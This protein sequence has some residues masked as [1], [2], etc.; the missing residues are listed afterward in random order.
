MA[1]RAEAMRADDM[2][3]EEDDFKKRCAQKVKRTAEW[4]AT[5]Q[6]TTGKVIALWVEHKK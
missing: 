3:G 4:N 2:D 5:P 6:S 1:F